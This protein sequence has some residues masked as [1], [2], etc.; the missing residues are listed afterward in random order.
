MVA[1]IAELEQALSIVTTTRKDGLLSVSY[2]DQP[3]SARP[4][5][6]QA[7]LTLSHL[8]HERQDASGDHI[9]QADILLQEGAASRYFSDDVLSRVVNEE[10]NHSRTALTVSPVKISPLFMKSSSPFNPLGI[11]SVPGTLHPPYGL[12][13]AKSVAAFLWRQ[14]VEVVEECASCKIL[15]V[16]TDEI[17]VFST[18]E[19]PSSASAENLALCFAIYFASCASLEAR[20]VETILHQ[21]GVQGALA[22]KHGFEQALAH[23]NFLDM[24]SDTTIKALTVYIGALN[25]QHRGKGTWI[26]NGLAMRAAR[27]LGFHV[28][29]GRLGMPPFRAEIRRR[30]WWCLNVFERRAHEDYG[31]PSACDSVQ[32]PS[33]DLPLNVN[34]EDL[35]PDMDSLPQPREGWTSMTPTLINIEAFTAI[36]ESTANSSAESSQEDVRQQIMARGRDVVN[37]YIQHAKLVVP[38][39]RHMILVSRFVLRKLDFDSRLKWQIRR[40]GTSPD[41]FI[42]EENMAEALEVMDLVRSLH[43]DELLKKYAVSSRAYTQYNIKLYILYHLF[44]R[45]LSPNAERAWK[46]IDDQVAPWN[47]FDAEIVGPKAEFLQTLATRAKEFRVRALT[48]QATSLGNKEAMTINGHCE[49]ANGHLG[50]VGADDSWLGHLNLSSIIQG[51]FLDDAILQQLDWTALSSNQQASALETL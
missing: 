13:P 8:P 2:L 30:I 21:D 28:D 14:Y 17:I 10:R 6:H 26:V 42:T 22:L 15:H 16:P 41:Q 33:V 1:R 45:P 50:D 35:Y 23:S 4:P 43:T 36:R 29:G 38:R 7:Q 49:L 48:E 51:G 47:G 27:S 20:E 5:D 3:Q 18:I 46:S 37:K 24:P 12:H 32:S 19:D 25:I 40:S 31:L 9:H 44:I 11:L 39:Q 34:D